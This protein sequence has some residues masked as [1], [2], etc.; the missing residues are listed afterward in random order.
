MSFIRNVGM[1]AWYIYLVIHWITE[2]S[3]TE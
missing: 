1:Q 3:T 2:T